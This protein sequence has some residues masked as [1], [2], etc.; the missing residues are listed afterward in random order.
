MLHR[1]EVDVARRLA[2]RAAD[3]QPGKAAVDGLV[4]RRRR[5]DRLAVAPHSLIPT[6]AQQL[7]GLLDHRF[8]LG[9]HLRRLRGEDVGHRAR[10]P[11]LL[12]QSLAVAAR[13]GCGVVFRG[14]P[15]IQG[16]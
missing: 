6:P 10:L 4:D 2:T 16:E 3:L 7:V 1:R 5:V 11:E 9:P 15:D 12:F 8:T 13:Q 14:H